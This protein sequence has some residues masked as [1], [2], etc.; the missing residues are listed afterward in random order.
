MDPL[1]GQLLGIM[2]RNG[3][4]P[5]GEVT[6]CDKGAMDTLYFDTLSLN[7]TYKLLKNYPTIIISDT[8]IPNLRT[9]ER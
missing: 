3:M 2:V 5:P 8:N 6:P 7:K 1:L 4:V 9:H